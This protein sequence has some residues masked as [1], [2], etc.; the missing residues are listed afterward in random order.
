MADSKNCFCYQKKPVEIDEIKIDGYSF[1]VYESLS[2]TTNSRDRSL[3]V[4]GCYT[5]NASSIDFCEVS[6]LWEIFE[7]MGARLGMEY[8]IDQRLR[9]VKSRVYVVAKDG[10]KVVGGSWFD[11]KEIVHICVLP[12]HRRMGIGQKIL[13]IAERYADE[14]I[15]CLWDTLNE[16]R[17]RINTEFFKKMGYNIVL[18]NGY[19]EATK[20]L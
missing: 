3:F 18:Y 20:K 11:D 14:K 16:E 2:N 5:H 10:K 6:F 17:H 19:T 12:E 13:S 15:R 8:E 4:A 1:S 7:P 9:F